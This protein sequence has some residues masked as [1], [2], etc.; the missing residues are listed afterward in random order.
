MLMLRCRQSFFV[1]RAMLSTKSF[2]STEQHRDEHTYMSKRID[3]WI[4]DRISHVHA[5]SSHVMWRYSF[6]SIACFKRK[7][8]RYVEEVGELLCVWKWNYVSCISPLEVLSMTWHYTLLCY[9]IH[10]RWAALQ[11]NS[12][13]MYR[14]K[15]VKLKENQKSFTRFSLSNHWNENLLIYKFP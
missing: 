10:M 14:R 11:K 7:L 1:L 15:S 4:S 6:K 12:S 5:A 8:C 9:R 13:N 2:H 3:L